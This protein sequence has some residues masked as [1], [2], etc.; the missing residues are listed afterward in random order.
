[1]I[2]KRLPQCD[3][4]RLVDAQHRDSGAAGLRATDQHGASPVEVP[5][6]VLSARMEEQRDIAGQWI[7]TSQV[8]SLL[9]VA[10]VATPTAVR[11]AVA[12]PMLLRDDVLD[13]EGCRHCSAIGK[14]AILAPLTGPVSNE[15]SQG[16]SHQEAADRFKRA[17]A[18]AWRMA[19]KS[20]V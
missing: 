9:E 2:D 12:T 20:M 3:P 13:M 18:F 17:R 14:M 16:P 6:P 10:V 4:V 1:V 7:P 19:M 5:F 15:L 11:G 8:W